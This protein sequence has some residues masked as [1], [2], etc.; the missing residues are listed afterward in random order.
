MGYLKRLQGDEA[1]AEELMRHA[2]AL[3]KRRQRQYGLRD[4]EPVRLNK[5]RFFRRLYWLN[6]TK[7]RQAR[8]VAAAMASEAEGKEGGHAASPATL[9]LPEEERSSKRAARKVLKQAAADVAGLRV[10]HSSA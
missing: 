1:A 6:K 4:Y 3:N 5:T 9:E 8:E 7:E 10:R 2:A